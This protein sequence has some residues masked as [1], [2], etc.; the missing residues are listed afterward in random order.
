[1][2][3]SGMEMSHIWLASKFELQGISNF[4]AGNTVRRWADQDPIQEVKAL[5]EE[6]EWL[7]HISFEIQVVIHS[8]LIASNWIS[9]IFTL[10]DSAEIVLCFSFETNFFK[11]V[12]FKGKLAVTLLSKQFSGLKNWEQA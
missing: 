1:M 9:E 7:T 10:G 8:K 3:L 2:F 5:S 11:S 6:G 12:S 4:H